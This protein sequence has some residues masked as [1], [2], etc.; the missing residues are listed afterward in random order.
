MLS[1]EAQ[2]SRITDDEHTIDL[3]TV[4]LCIGHGP[5]LY[6]HIQIRCIIYFSLNQVQNNS[7]IQLLTGRQTLI[8]VKTNN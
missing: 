1:K 3:H 4:L 6:N 8:N 5:I 2:V 7:C